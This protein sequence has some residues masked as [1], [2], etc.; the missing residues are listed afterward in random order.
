M[1]KHLRD[2]TAAHRDIEL[3]GAAIEILEKVSGTQRV[4]A[5]L[6]KM[7]GKHLVRLDAAAGKLGAPYPKA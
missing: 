2:Y 5:T 6:Q 4:I 1:R 7:Q 3:T